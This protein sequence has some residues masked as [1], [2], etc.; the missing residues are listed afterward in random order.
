MSR[1][2][3]FDLKKFNSWRLDAFGQN[4]LLPDTY[5]ELKKWI[6]EYKTLGLWL[7]LG[8]NV[9]LPKIVKTPIVI[10]QKTLKSFESLSDNKIYAQCGASCAQVSKLC[11]KLGYENA[12]FLAGIPGTIGGALAMNAGAF[13]GET[14]DNIVGVD[15]IDD[16]GHIYH[17]RKDQFSPS[18]RHLHSIFNVRFLAAYFQ[19]KKGCSDK[20]SNYLKNCISKRNQTQPIGTFNCGSVFKNPY[21]KYAAQLIESCGLKGLK[22]NHAVINELHANFILNEGNA[23]YDDMVSLIQTIQKTILDQKNV[24]LET[25]VIIVE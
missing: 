7:G 1:H 4:V 12:A 14:W 18:Y 6:K 8:S 15:V 21:P 22:S 13:G 3:N 25:E 24:L 5:H 10:T 9:L 16:N 2:T 23:S 17:L 11:C 20:A 19:F